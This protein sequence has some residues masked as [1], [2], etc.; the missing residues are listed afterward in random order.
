[1]DVLTEF[2]PRV[3]KWVQQTDAT[4]PNIRK[5]LKRNVRNKHS[6]ILMVLVPAGSV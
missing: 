3:Q 6:R 4:S 5:G 1:M 2:E